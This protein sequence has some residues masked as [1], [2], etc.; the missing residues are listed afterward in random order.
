M[1]YR[2]LRSGLLHRWVTVIVAGGQN[3]GMC[4]NGLV[5]RVAPCMSDS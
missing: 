2:E 5:F 1:N 4:H 3:H